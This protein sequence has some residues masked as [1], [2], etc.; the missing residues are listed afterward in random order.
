M[1]E[2]EENWKNI[3]F[4]TEIEFT[5]DEIL[6]IILDYNNLRDTLVKI[7]KENENYKKFYIPNIS[8]PYEAAEKGDINLL[9]NAKENGCPID[10]GTIG[11]AAR[12][13][14]FDCVKY[15]IEIGTKL[16]SDVC[17][18]AVRGNQIEMVKYLRENGCEF[19]EEC[20]S[21]A[22]SFGLYDM[23]VYLDESEFPWPKYFIPICNNNEKLKCIEYASKKNKLNDNDLN[24]YLSFSK[25]EYREK[26]KLLFNKE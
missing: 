15:M 19:T 10:Y 22:I 26:I 4:D 14:Y 24:N 23:L 1:T 11:F 17:I 13:G 3:Q 18:E 2:I 25:G 9:K 21:S 12:N 5:R 20:I 8:V 6:K 16:H 7:A